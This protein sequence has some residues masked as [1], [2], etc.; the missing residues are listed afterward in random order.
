LDNNAALLSHLN[1]DTAAR[2]IAVTPGELEAFVKAG[3]IRRA[4]KNAYAIPVLV[5]DYIGYLKTENSRK[6]LSPKQA[7]IAEHLDISE[8][9]VREFLTDAGIDHKQSTLPEIR[10]AY[11]RRLREQAAG[12]A[13]FGDLDLATERAG[14]AKAQRERIEMQNAVTRKELAP[15]A[16]ITEVLAKT[17]AKIAGQFDAI[18]SLVRRRA[19]QLTAE[20]IALI[21]AEIVKV[22]NTVAKMSL[23]DIKE[24]DAPSEQPLISENA[25]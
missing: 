12:R 6:E 21:T 4:D 9:S 25:E 19:P 10:I 15:V 7:G 16:L 14:L 13:T 8:R 20:D 23:E 11:I 3:T 2:L 18:P 1:H 24:D 22:R 5:Q 17:A